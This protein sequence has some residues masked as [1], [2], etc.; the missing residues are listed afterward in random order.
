MT[1]SICGILAV[2]APFSRTLP[3]QEVPVTNLGLAVGQAT[4]SGS[5]ILFEVPEFEQGADL[6]ADGDVADRVLHVTDLESGQTTNLEL[7]SGFFPE[8]AGN[9][10]VLRVV[11][12]AQSGD[13]N[14]DGDTWDWVVHVHDLS[15]GVTTNLELAGYGL[16]AVGSA[17][18]RVVIGVS[19]VEQ[20]ADLN[21]DGDLADHVLHV[22]DLSTGT[23]TNE[24]VSG[25]ESGAEV[26]DSHV[27][28][29]L[30]ESTE[31]RDLNGDGD[32]GDWWVAHSY[33]LESGQTTNLGLS[34]EY[35]ALVGKRAVLA[36]SEARQGVDLNADGDREDGVLHVV[37]LESGETT[38]LGLAGTV[39]AL[40]ESRLVFAVQEVAQGQDL[41]GD[42]ALGDD[43]NE[44]GVLESWESDR[45]LHVRDLESGESTNLALAGTEARVSEGAVAFRA[46]EEE[47]GRDLNGDSDEVDDVVHVRDLALG[48]T[49]NLGLAAASGLHLVGAHLVFRVE[50]DDQGLDLNGD[51]DLGDDVF[52][53]RDLSQAVTTNLR[54][55][56]GASSLSGSWLAMTVSEPGQGE[57]LNGD[58]DLQDGVA[59]V[60][61]LRSGAQTNLGL[62]AWE[63]LLAGER[64]VLQVPEGLEGKDLNG[65]G[66]TGDVVLHVADLEGLEPVRLFRRGD[67]NGDGGV[68]ISDSICT[69]L[70]LFGGVAPHGCLAVTNTNGDGTAD[71]SDAVYLLQHLFLAGAPPAPPYP[72]CGPG[73]L[74]TDAGLCPIPPPGCP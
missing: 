56:G 28:F 63:I 2:L 21:G 29:W 22:H 19:E 40:T 16:P 17:G 70:W 60:R 12:S 20:G 67:C 58:G 54:L 72:D 44:D 41:N 3:G 42:G 30:S 25:M 59:H 9:I 4:V 5:F 65:D 49:T 15:T 48:V 10:V 1:V 24:G 53:I 51:G 36:V 34:V 73:T 23:T 57:D 39:S 7:S 68:D 71:L 18:A 31:G 8:V 11:E 74:P 66:D 62:A 61:D 46:D 6:N 38:G 33:D 43:R 64:L 50:E 27:L 47:Q 52:H 69:L 14:G 55:A 35:S 37:D 26:S 32:S 13:L 45:T